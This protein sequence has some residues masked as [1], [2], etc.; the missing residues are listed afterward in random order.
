[1]LKDHFQVVSSS[2][3]M[4]WNWLL[5]WK[6]TIIPLI[7]SQLTNTIYIHCKLQLNTL[8]SQRLIT[9]MISLRQWRKRP[10]MNVYKEESGKYSLLSKPTSFE[11]FRRK[12][13]TIIFVV[14][15]L[16]YGLILRVLYILYLHYSIYQLSL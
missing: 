15:L 16:R 9:I 12:I 13:S 10:A 8:Q 11:Y 14:E 5:K 1:M 3:V 4:I 2:K 7:I 6:G